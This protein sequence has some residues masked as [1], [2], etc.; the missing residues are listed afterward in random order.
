MGQS[1]RVGAARVRCGRV[2][3]QASFP[4]LVASLDG[5]FETEVLHPH[6]TSLAGSKEQKTQ[7]HKQ[8]AHS[9]PPQ[10]IFNFQHGGCTV[11]SL[12]L[13]RSCKCAR[14]PDNSAQW[15]ASAATSL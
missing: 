11:K 9:E 15:D 3:N 2:A 4:R 1:L 13:R 6:E 10:S 14:S 5:H 8:Y 12:E 7:Q